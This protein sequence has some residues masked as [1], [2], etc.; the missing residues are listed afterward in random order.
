[1][2]NRKKGPAM[3]SPRVQNDRMRF[4]EAWRLR[5]EALS[6]LDFWQEMAKEL[7]FD[8]DRCV[9]VLT[10]LGKRFYG[11]T[12]VLTSGT[13]MNGVIHVGDKS[14][15]GG[16]SGESASTGMT[17][18]FAAFGFETGRMKTGTPARID[19]RSIDFSQLEQQPGEYPAQSFSFLR[20]SP[21]R[22]KEQLCCYIG[23]TTEAVHAILHESIDKSPLFNG[24]IQG[25]GPRY[26]PSIEDKIVKFSDKPSHQLFVEPEGWHT[27]EVYLN[28]FSSSLPEE[29]QYAALRRI[30]GFEHA[31]MFRPGYAV[32]Y[33]FFPPHQLKYSLET[34]PIANLFFAGQVNGT[35]GYEEAAA[36]GIMAGINAVRKVRD[37]APIVLGR[38][39]A[40]IGVLIDDLINRST[41]EPYRMFTSRAEYRIRLRQDNADLRLTKLGYSIG[42]AG[43]DRLQKLQAK[44]AAIEQL[45]RVMEQTSIEPSELNGQL[46]AM[47][48]SPLKQKD[49]AAKLLARPEVTLEMLQNASSEI[50]E[51]VANA[52]EEA[53]QQV[54]IQIMYDGYLKKEEE[55]AEKMQR[56]E[57]VNLPPEFD[58]HALQALST[59]ARQKLD[60]IRP[61]TLGQAARISG[62]SASDVQVLMVRMGR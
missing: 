13:F 58:Y 18:Q 32:E 60:Q 11:T 59:E 25:S 2:L 51:A 14:F 12:V 44:E 16:R 21:L 43:E 41:D 45:R 30:P 48:K 34:K 9:G 22:D 57:H 4:A 40:Y 3:W 24:Q 29:V 19:G 20:P 55:M 31:K 33:D 47:G 5:L 8:G 56:L 36:Q 1:M 46:E 37:E 23:E 49:K 7:I 38:E 53:A 62:V 6:N 26:C 35:T 28:G 61:E 15:G 27:H 42:L 52:G 54:D 17:P 39:E 10:G 50:R